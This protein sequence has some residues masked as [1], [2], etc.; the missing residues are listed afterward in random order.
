MQAKVINDA[1]N[2]FPPT[3]SR[4]LPASASSPRCRAASWPTTTSSSAPIRGCVGR[5]YFKIP[6]GLK[7]GQHF[8]NVKFPKSLVRV[9]FRI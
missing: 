6:G 8:L 3:R 9:P 2:Y 1:I 5:L 4:R 7:H